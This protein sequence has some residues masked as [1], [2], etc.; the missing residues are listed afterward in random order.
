ME[1]SRSA[2]ENGI[3]ETANAR[4]SLEATIEA[5]KQ[6][7]QQID[8]IATAATE[9]ASASGEIAESAGQISQLAAENVSGAE[10]AVQALK[11]MA[12]LANELDG[13]IRQFKL[14]GGGQP[15]VRLA[16]GPQTAAAMHAVHS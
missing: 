15:G 12:E 16:R 2:V 3:T 9:Q 8:L 1:E 7:E 10:E 5:S 14:E 11:N 13:I 6:V 4:K